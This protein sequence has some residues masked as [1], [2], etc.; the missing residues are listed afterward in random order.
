VWSSRAHYSRWGLLLAR[1]DEAWRAIGQA[2][3][4]TAHGLGPVL[5]LTSHLP[6]KGD[7]AH[8]VLQAAGVEP[9]GLM[10]PEALQQLRRYSLGTEPS[11]PA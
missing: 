3:V 1:T 8:R 2:S 4:L 9:I 7:A 6:R 10:S 5:L 11:R